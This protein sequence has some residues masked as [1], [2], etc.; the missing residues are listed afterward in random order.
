MK[1]VPFLNKRYIKRGTFSGKMVYKRVKGSTSEWSLPVFNFVK[2]PPSSPGALCAAHKE[3]FII[4][5][6]SG[7]LFILDTLPPGTRRKF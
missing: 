2:Y 1:G 5:N 4:A 3:Y 6:K 7:F